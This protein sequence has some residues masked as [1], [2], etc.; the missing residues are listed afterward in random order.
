MAAGAA[1]G[2]AG[3]AGGQLSQK[4]HVGA[5]CRAAEHPGLAVASGGLC[6]PEARPWG[7]ELRGARVASCRPVS[8]ARPLPASCS[9]RVQQ[10][11]PHVLGCAAP[12]IGG[13]QGHTG[14]LLTGGMGTHGRPQLNP[15]TC[16]GFFWARGPEGRSTS[17]PLPCQGPPQQRPFLVSPRP[18]PQPWPCVGTRTAASGHGGCG[19]GPRPPPLPQSCSPQSKSLPGGPSDTRDAVTGLPGTCRVGGGEPACALRVGCPALSLGPGRPS[20]RA[21]GLHA[22]GPA[23]TA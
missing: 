12:G 11:C 9:S 15:I 18:P 17:S 16:C 21:R 23:F 13:G 6:I 19:H 20:P 14:P 8:G 7:A 22:T 2:L 5:G 1:G 3:V 4:G 10:G